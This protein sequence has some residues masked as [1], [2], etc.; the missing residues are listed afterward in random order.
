MDF[1]PWQQLEASQMPSEEELLMAQFQ[2][3]QMQQPA[4]PALRTASP[5]LP[6]RV[7]QSS[8][9]E[10]LV[11]DYMQ[12]A[13]RARKQQQEGIGIYEK[14]IQD[15]LAQKDQRLDLSPLAALA[16]SWTG[17]KLTPAALANRPMA[18]EERKML[19]AKLQDELQKR[20]S[21][22][23][24]GLASDL[25]TQLLLGAQGQKTAQ[26]Q[27][28]QAAE[29]AIPGYDQD[30]TVKPSV[31]EV[32]K[33]RE[34]VAATK[35]VT[36]AVREYIGL[37]KKNGTFQVT[38]PDADRM[39]ALATKIKLNQKN[40]E[41]LGALAGPDMAILDSL[42][43]GPSTLGAI[44]GSANPEN[45]IAGLETVLKNTDATLT[46]K[47]SARGYMKKGASAPAAVPS[48]GG[49]EAAA[50]ARLAELRAKRA[51]RN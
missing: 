38:G 49:D 16:D 37:V 22:Y 34:G 50:R 15:I 18:P 27:Q 12:S 17:S 45:A 33:L 8:P 42:I 31:S 41:E 2:N 4:A 48:G 47:L 26:K 32:G 30:P 51:A 23:S 46:N 11:K 39:E 10:Q 43:K 24:A 13:Q 25:K 3:Q 6:S 21:D 9:Q 44:F 29:V 7:Q 5:G 28:E 20:K 19:S 14:S 35:T 40:T 1:S 36:D